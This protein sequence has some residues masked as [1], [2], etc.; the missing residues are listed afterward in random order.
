MYDLSQMHFDNPMALLKYLSHQNGMKLV[1]L[2]R[3]DIKK[4]ALASLSYEMSQRNI[5]LD[6][7]NFSHLKVIDDCL[8]ETLSD[9]LFK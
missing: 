7:I 1:N 6:E 2:S 5:I 9:Q 3:C 4:E 8:L